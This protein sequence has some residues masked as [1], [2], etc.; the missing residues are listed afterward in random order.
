MLGVDQ[1]PEVLDHARA[2]L[3]PFRDR[4]RIERARMS[5]LADVASALDA[6]L[7]GVFLDLGANSL[8][9]DS[10]ERGFSFQAD[11]P[12][13]MRMDPDRQRTAADIVNHWDESDLADLFYYE[14]GE[15]RSRPIA[16]AGYAPRGTSP[17]RT[18]RGE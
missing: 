1:D 10:P 17:H 16:R 5:Q 3:A 14:G 15:R 13:D 7:V 8:H 9:F 12:L 11:G 4:V 6:P 18:P 2:R